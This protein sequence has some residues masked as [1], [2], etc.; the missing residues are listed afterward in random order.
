MN[1]NWMFP[2][3]NRESCRVHLGN[4]LNLSKITQEP[5]SEK[6]K[7]KLMAHILILIFYIQIL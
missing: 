7:Y 2:Y 4:I 6:E 3:L 1:L 5:F